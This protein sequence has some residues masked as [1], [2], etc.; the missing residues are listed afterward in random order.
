ML[1]ERLRE[2]AC[3]KRDRGMGS[4]EREGWGVEKKREW[5]CVERGSR[6]GGKEEGSLWRETGEEGRGV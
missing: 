5:V 3:G 2:G 4:T 1:R 6:E